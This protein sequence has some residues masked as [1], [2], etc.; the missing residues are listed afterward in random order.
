MLC[1]LW[2][3]EPQGTLDDSWLH[4]L[5]TVLQTSGPAYLAPMYILSSS[6]AP[7]PQL[8]SPLDLY[9]RKSGLAVPLRLCLWHQLSPACIETMIL[10]VLWDVAGP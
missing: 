5:L 7:A 3:L 4:S 8:F 10:T 2:L 1:A 9:I 6:S